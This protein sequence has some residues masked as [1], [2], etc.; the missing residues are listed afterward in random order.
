MELIANSLAVTTAIAGAGFYYTIMAG[1]GGFAGPKGSFA[2]TWSPQALALAVLSIGAA[3]AY[4]GVSGGIAI[5]VAV[6]WHEWGHVIAYRV[7]GHSD[8]RFR[9]IPLFGGVAISD[10]SPKDHAAECFVTLMGPGFSVSLVVI[11]ALAESWLRSTGS[12]LAYEAH[13]AMVL[14]GAINAF[15][16]L[17][18]WPLD[19]G[20]ALRSITVTVAPRLA[21]ILTTVMSA[22]LAAIAVMKQMWLLLMFALMGYGYARQAQATE[23]GLAPMTGGQA[24]L[25]SVGYLAIFGAHLLAGL[26]LFRWILRF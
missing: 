4:Y 5:I 13:Q 18:L 11:L 24:V 9:L 3:V 6:M 10:Q 25:A 2:L 23:R 26:P 22:T 20:R 1:L 19:G 12:P 15:N 16:M 14:A 7:A 21:G 8:A 17:P